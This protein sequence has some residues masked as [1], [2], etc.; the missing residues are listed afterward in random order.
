M[1]QKQFCI[2][3]LH[4][5]M[6]GKNTVQAK[7]WL[8]KCYKDSAPLETTIKRWFANFKRA[9]RDTGDVERSECPNEVV[10]PENIKKSTKTF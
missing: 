6:M 9:C 3:I 8:E 2:L 1:D 7:H 5:F 10:T 4:C